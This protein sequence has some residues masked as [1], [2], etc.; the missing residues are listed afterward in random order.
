MITGAA[1]VV[2]PDS[3]NATE[4]EAKGS[5]VATSAIARVRVIGLSHADPTTYSSQQY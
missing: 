3:M 5:V 2:R 1:K 4:S